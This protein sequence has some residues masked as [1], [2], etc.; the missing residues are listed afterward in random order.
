LP[1]AV[2]RGLPVVVGDERSPFAKALVAMTPLVF[3]VTR[4]PQTAPREQRR[5]LLRGRR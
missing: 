3:D 4:S 1:V 5:F 2:N